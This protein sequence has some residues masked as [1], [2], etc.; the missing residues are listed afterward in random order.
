M[1][2]EIAYARAAGIDYWA[3]DWYRPD[4]GLSTARSLYLSSSHRNDVKWCLIVGT[5]GF[6]D[7]D[8]RWL[9]GEFRTANYQKVLGDRPLLYIFNANRQCGP[10]VKALRDEAAAAGC[11][12]PFIVLMGWGPAIAEAAAATG[13]DAIGAYVNPIGDGTAFTAAMAHER[14]RW[15]ALRRTGCQIVPTI[16]T[17]WD[18]RPFLDHPVSWY[19]GATERN[20]GER[21]TPDQLAEQLATCLDFV[22]QHPDA[23]LANAALIYAWN[24]NAEGGWIIPTLE[25]VRDGGVPLRLDALR[26]VLKPDVPR[27]SGWPTP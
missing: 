26:N 21:A 8:R 25:E 6:L 1:D 24:E 12:A 27:G 5:S 15:E 19:P 17:G 3:F 14:A 22:K 18:P 11:P 2:R 4:D 9:I 13:A 20:W 10:M 7:E 23:T 16:T